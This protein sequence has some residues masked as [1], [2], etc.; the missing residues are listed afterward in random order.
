M[1]WMEGEVRKDIPKGDNT[2]ILE[3]IWNRRSWEVQG[4]GKREE[5]QLL[6]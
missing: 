2:R 5:F 3:E 6:R 1:K 4:E